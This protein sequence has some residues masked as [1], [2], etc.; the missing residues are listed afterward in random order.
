MSN[1]EKI[2]R[3]LELLKDIGDKSDSIRAI[4]HLP[5][6]PGQYQDYPDDVHP[7][8]RKAL[9]AKGFTSLYSHQRSSWEAL[10]EGKNIVVVTPTASG[11]TLCYNLPV[12]DAIL[13][14]PGTRALYLFPTKA[15]SQDQQAELDDINTRL[16]EEIRVFTYDG[17]T[18]QDAR[19]AIRARGHIV[20]TNPDMLHAGILPHHTKWIKLFENLKYIVIDEL[21]NYRGIF[22]SHLANVLRR[23]RRIA[24]FYGADPQFILCTATIANPAEMAEKTIEAPVAL[25]E[26]N[27]APRG[28]K[29]FVFYTPPVVNAALGIR[30]SYVNES[31]RIASIFL[32]NGLQTIVFAGSRL[33]T[34]VLLT[35]LKADIETS[36]QKEGLV[37]GY[38]GGYLPLKRREI[39]KGL[40]TGEILGVVS[41]NAL[42]LGIDIGTLDVAV[43]AGYPGTIASTWQ[44]AGR[45]GR[46]TGLSAAV[47]VATSSPLDQFIINNPEY[48]FSKSPEMALINPDNLSILV[49]HIECAAFELPFEDGEKFGRAEIGE[50]LNFLEEDKLL[51]HS[52]DK[53]FWT[54][55]AYPADAISLRSISS[56]NFVVVD[57]TGEARVIAEVDFTSAL[58][59][60][61]PKAIYIVEGEQ[62]FVEKLDFEERKAYVKRTDIDYYTDAIDYTKITILDLFDKK[63]LEAGRVSHGE[64][65]VATQVVG[66][67]KIKFHTMENVG[68]GD[69]TLPQNEMHTTA[70]WL[71]VSSALMQTIPFP[72]EQRVNGL[73]GVAYLLHHVSPLF[74]MCDIHDVG[75]SIGDNTSGE[76]LPPRIMPARPAVQGQE[77]MPVVMDPDFEPNI[78]IYD[79]YPG[80]IGLSPSLFSLEGRLLD[81]ALRTLEVCPCRDGCP[82]CVGATNESG[83]DAKKVARAIL[84]GLLGLS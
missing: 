56:D 16:P 20:L 22:G 21:H 6:Q 66:F 42:E 29:Y 8:L 63:A 30:R 12:L 54:S 78:F 13:K 79:N 5:A 45:A 82:S 73:F 37:R 34:E 46:K 57:I 11:K 14:D 2:L 62:Y 60:L 10:K 39:E 61:H 52:K 7:A 25:I 58:T 47:L 1:E 75:V 48:F 32:K 49:S 83:K 41:T 28:G 43:L 67:K 9:A 77:D 74:M 53:W 38:R 76:S 3:S 68:A 69:L 65:H 31:R 51:H 81:H 55:E 50:I 64:V 4:K 26:D 40:R 33:I 80:G 23:L 18:P 36:I 70:Y 71:T 15:L 72:A 17:D 19:K 24:R 84:Q 27:G 35:Y 44:R 59:A